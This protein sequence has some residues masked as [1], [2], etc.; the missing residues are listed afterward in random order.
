M[1]LFIDR[2]IIWH[3]L[4]KHLNQKFLLLHHDL[5]PKIRN[6]TL[7]FLNTINIGLVES[8]LIMYKFYFSFAKHSSTT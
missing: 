8:P 6:S 4:L 3:A 5:F 2:K 1:F 7:F